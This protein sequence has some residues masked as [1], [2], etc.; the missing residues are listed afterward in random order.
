[1]GDEHTGG[2]RGEVDEEA[3]GNW[4]GSVDSGTWLR[5]W[6]AGAAGDEDAGVDEGI[7]GTTGGSRLMGFEGLE[8]CT[9]RDNWGRCREDEEDMTVTGS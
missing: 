9:A 3:M 5:I 4:V 7:S 6:V 8:T 2:I 1:M